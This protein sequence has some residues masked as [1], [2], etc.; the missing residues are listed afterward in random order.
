VFDSITYDKGAGVLA[1]LE[2]YIGEE[3]FREGVRRHM[4]RFP[5][6]VANSDDFVTSMAE[7]SG[8]PEIAGAFRSFIDQPGVPLVE[9]RLQCPIDAPPRVQ[10]SQSRYLPLG[11]AI[12]TEEQSWQLPICVSHWGDSGR[13]RTCAL[14]SVSEDLIELDTPSCPESVHPNAEGAGYYRFSLDESGWTTLIATASSLTPNEALAA[15]DSLDAG[16]RAGVIS[17]DIFVDGLVAFAARPEWDVASAVSSRLVSIG[18]ILDTGQYSVLRGL[19]K[20][21]FRP[22]LLD[23]E[24]DDSDNALLARASLYN[25][26]ALT[27]EDETIRADLAALAA[28]RIG[29]GGSAPDADA[30]EPDFLDTALSVGV[31]EF[32]ESFF[33]MLFAVVETTSDAAFRQAALNALARAEDISLARRLREML[34]DG[35]IRGEEALRMLRIQLARRA[36]RLDAWDWV[37]ANADSVISMTPETFRSSSIPSFGQSFCTTELGV[38]LSNFVAANAEALPGHERSLAQI[39]E[40]IGLCDSLRGARADEL[41]AAI[42]RAML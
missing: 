25:L 16:F 34:R 32:G 12:T 5:H 11:S 23:L 1:M 13:G 3:A 29:Y 40:Q 30:I 7:G 10:V 37:K 9:A 35:D 31:H 24:Q 4:A 20:A 2:N 36:T 39:Q 8:H 41:Y 6:G 38:D 28:E 15:V 22:R 27:A 42:N 33:D 21:T 14:V 17:A 18:A 19:L 26:L